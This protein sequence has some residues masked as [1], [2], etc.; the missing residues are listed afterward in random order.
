[1]CSFYRTNTCQNFA[2]RTD[3]HHVPSS[4][5]TSPI[6]LSFPSSTFVS[7]KFPIFLLTN[8]FFLVKMICIR[9]ICARETRVDRDRLYAVG[10][11]K[12]ADHL[13]ISRT[14]SSTDR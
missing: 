1:S 8:V 13:A 9:R 7:N 5:K 12:L 3:S 14:I 6:L 4:E 11:C 10:G 2:H